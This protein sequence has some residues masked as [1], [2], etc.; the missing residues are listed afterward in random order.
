LYTGTFSGAAKKYAEECGDLQDEI[1]AE[2]TQLRS[3]RNLQNEANRVADAKKE[4]KA[5]D[6]HLRNEEIVDLVIKVACEDVATEKKTI[7]LLEKKQRD[8]KKRMETLGEAGRCRPMTAEEEK[9]FK[10]LKELK[11]KRKARQVKEAQDTGTEVP[12]SDDDDDVVSTSDAKDIGQRN[13]RGFK[14]AFQGLSKEMADLSA[15]LKAEASQKGSGLTVEQAQQKMRQL[16]DDIEHGLQMT[17][18]ER[19]QVRLMILK[20]YAKGA[21]RLNI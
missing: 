9:E 1:E 12:P 20:Q 14:C 5:C 3:L 4:L 16:E 17:S 21:L 7:A 10:L 13:E 6:K 18:A 2:W 15:C 19:D 11:E 8:Y